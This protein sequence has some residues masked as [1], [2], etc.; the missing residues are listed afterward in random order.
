MIPPPPP[1][2]PAPPSL[3]TLLGDA[4]PAVLADCR[5]HTGEILT[6]APA[7]GGNVSHVFRV[8]GS[9]RNAIVKAR[10]SRFAKI[11][12]LRT[13]PALIADER[14]ALE[15]Y[16]TAAPGLFPR[17]LGFHDQAHAMVLTDVFP[18][19]LNYHQHLHRRPATVA[20]TTR[21]GATLRGIHQATREVHTRIRSQGDVW[22]REH[23]FD[24]CLRAR[25]HK[26]L[27]E[28]CRQMAARPGQQLI[29]GDLA[30]KNLSLANDG[31]ALCDL[32]N[33][34]RGWPLYDVAYFL[35]H[36][37]IHHLT[38]P[39]HLPALVPALLA[40]YLGTNAPERAEDPLMATVTAGVVLYRLAS[41]TVPYPLAQPPAVTERYRD[42]VLELLDS[43]TFIVRDLV[44]AAG[45]ERGPA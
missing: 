18:D 10:R 19:G 40:G 12:T 23:T 3:A 24:F 14:R 33:V 4:L 22:F 21:L 43:G 36:L 27:D 9:R 5:R 25:G 2:Q 8:Q 28:A 26:T 34:H 42:R 38:R 32:D 16:G 44:N 13:D 45:S 37:L 39:H 20:E 15:V 29:L 6:I 35:A 31:V 7:T 11:P 1:P 30:P 17:V 41:T